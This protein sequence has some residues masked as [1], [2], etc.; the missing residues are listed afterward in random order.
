MPEPRTTPR[1]VSG[2]VRC[3]V[4]KGAGAEPP[5]EWFPDEFPPMQTC[6]VCNGTG[7]VYEEDD[8]EE[9]DR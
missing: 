7:E 5:D 8:R 1:E 9:D 6:A 3:P 4:C 2:A